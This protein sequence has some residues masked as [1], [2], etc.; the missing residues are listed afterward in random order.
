MTVLNE[1]FEIFEREILK[2]A[3]PEGQAG[4]ALRYAVER[5]GYLD[6]MAFDFAMTPASLGKWLAASG[7]APA[8]AKALEKAC[9]LASFGAVHAFLEANP[10][11]RAGEAFAAACKSLAARFPDPT[12]FDQ[13]QAVHNGLLAA[14]GAGD[15]AAY[16]KFLR[17]DYEP[18]RGALVFSLGFDSLPAW[19]EEISGAFDCSFRVAENEPL[20]LS[21]LDM[22][23]ALEKKTL[24]D[25]LARALARLFPG[26]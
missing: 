3:A 11:I 14:L 21:G 19:G 23:I 24:K 18:M 4:S 1:C 8:Y 10:R 20:P 2:A 13:S 15:L 7:F 22:D 16:E 26:L 9:R 17:D 25:F 12:T 5:D 6:K